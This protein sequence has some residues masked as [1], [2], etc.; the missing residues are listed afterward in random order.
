M[1]RIEDQYRAAEGL[2][3]TLRDQLDRLSRF[4]D[5]PDLQDQV[6]ANLAALTRHTE[7]LQRA[8]AISND[9]IWRRY[10]TSA[11]ITHSITGG[12]LILS[13]RCVRAWILRHRQ[14]DSTICRWE[15]RTTRGGIEACQY[16]KR[17]T[18]RVWPTTCSKQGTTSTSDSNSNRIIS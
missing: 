3:L 2:V 18:K 8:T 13:S 1:S 9:I 7:V 16:I 12:Y 4:P 11:A 15:R 14:Q 5:N 6:C 17:T 10:E